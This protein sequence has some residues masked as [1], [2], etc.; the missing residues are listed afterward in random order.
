MEG[1][2]K[3]LGSMSEEAAS[4]GK[5]YLEKLGVTVRLN[6]RVKNY[7]GTFVTLDNEEKIRSNTL[8]W[9]SGVKGNLLPG[10]DPAVIGRGSRIKVDHF[11]K[12]EG[13]QNIFA[14]GDVC[15][16]SAD[17]FPEGHPQLAQ[18]AIQQGKNLALN[19]YNLKIKKP[20]KFFKY[21]DKGSMATVGRNKAVVDMKNFQ[22]AGIL[23]W[24]VWM[25]VH[26]LF[27]IGF[28]NKL[29]TFINW[30]WNYLTYDRATRLIVRPWVKKGE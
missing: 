15:V 20:L 5:E 16:M 10:I 9:A 14:V 22:F 6:T 7:D 23:A 11:N 26:L 27:L 21:F 18:V 25:F 19:L 28:R 4:K 30:M 17:K 29:T 12:V 3:V 8:V 13:Y 24:F 1:S 2:A